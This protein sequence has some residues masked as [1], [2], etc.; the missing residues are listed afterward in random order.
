MLNL[1]DSANRIS[2]WDL[3]QSRRHNVNEFFTSPLAVFNWNLRNIKSSAN[4]DATTTAGLVLSVDILPEGVSWPFLCGGFVGLSSLV[5][6]DLEY[7]C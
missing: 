6:R 1:F 2:W 7:Y 4:V 5:A 3:K